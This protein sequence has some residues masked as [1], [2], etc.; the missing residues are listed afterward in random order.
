M[1]DEVDTLVHQID[2]ATLGA[3]KYFCDEHSKEEFLKEAFESLSDFMVQFKQAC[4]V[5]GGFLT[6]S[7]A[8]IVELQYWVLKN[9]ME[10]WRMYNYTTSTI[11]TMIGWIFRGLCNRIATVRIFKIDAVIQNAFLIHI[12]GATLPKLEGFFQKP[13]GSF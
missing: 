1:L 5:C 10:A 6:H 11:T 13:E 2:K 8:C 9:I 4:K 12:Y 3:Q 7:I